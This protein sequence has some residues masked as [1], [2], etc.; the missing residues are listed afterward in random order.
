MF[1]TTIAREKHSVVRSFIPLLR[2]LEGV[3]GEKNILAGRFIVKKGNGNGLRILNRGYNYPRKAYML[4]ARI[5]G[6]I[7]YFFVKIE[8]KEA[9]PIEEFIRGYRG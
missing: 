8:E 1:K 2:S 9:G 6:E 4:Q 5:S 3:F 7:Q